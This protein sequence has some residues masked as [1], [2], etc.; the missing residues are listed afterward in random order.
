MGSILGANLL[1]ELLYW[2]VNQGL[3]S[4]KYTTASFPTSGPPS[5]MINSEPFEQEVERM[6]TVV[7]KKRLEQVIN[8]I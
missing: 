8:L 5:R 3:Q 4:I 6:N 2:E 7:R 1:R